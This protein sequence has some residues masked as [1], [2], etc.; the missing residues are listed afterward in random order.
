MNRIKIALALLALLFIA[1]LIY[2]RKELAKQ[3]TPYEAR[4]VTPSEVKALPKN[5]TVMVYAPWCR[6]CLGMKPV[7]NDAA[8]VVAGIDESKMVTILNGS[9]YSD[10]MN[11]MGFDRFPTIFKTDG[12]DNKKPVVYEGDNSRHSLVEFMRSNIY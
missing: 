7:Y 9:Q 12:K 6:Y 8:A 10:F 2:F 3:L 11:D 4:E 1:G 5:S